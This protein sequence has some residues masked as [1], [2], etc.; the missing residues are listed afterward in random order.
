MTALY[1]WQDSLN[2]CNEVVDEYSAEIRI[3]QICDEWGSSKGGLSTFNRQLAVHLAKQPSLNVHCQLSDVSESDRENARNSK[4]TL[5]AADPVPGSSDPFLKLHQVPSELQ[6]PDIVISHG[7][8]FGTAAHFIRKQVQSCIWVHFVHV[9][10][11]EM[12]KHKD[13]K[14]AIGENNAKDKDEVN[15]CKAAN[16]VVAVGPHLGEKYS[17]DLTRA[18]KRVKIFT[19]GISEE[20]Q[21][22]DQSNED[23]KTFR[24]F[25]FGRG[26]SEDFRLK[27]YD[28][29]AN[30]VA[31]LGRP[32]ILHSVGAACGEEEDVK[33]RF[34]RKTK[35]TDGNLTIH[36]YCN[37]REELKD[38]LCTATVVLLPS[39]AEAFGLI[40]LEAISAGVPVLVSA[41]SGLGITLKELPF[42]GTCVVETHKPEEWAGK[43]KSLCEK[44][45][46]ERNQEA[47]ELRI[48]YGN[49]H[50][51]DGE[52]SKL[53][54]L[55]R[56][57]VK[58][59]PIAM[60]T[61]GNH[62]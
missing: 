12:G 45:R 52:C 10:C 17:T 29:A 38:L 36:K 49:K 26:S 48:M 59:S 3:L 23:K 30:A 47:R 41:T 18:A 13:N 60:D 33:K 20:F 57:L 39:R 24:I 62:S 15:L 16:L 22:L 61:N 34:L 54:K 14:S 50:S 9:D 46:A 44:T 7:R 43:I 5:I 40:G 1:I 19:P 53:S 21:N 25:V 55:F 11:P 2:G 51:W 35:I 28:V 56:D 37:D 42:G 8:K 32:Y 6:N 4:I 58:R 27:G 31:E